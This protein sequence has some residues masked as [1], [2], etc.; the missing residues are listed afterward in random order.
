MLD[1]PL[2]ATLSS[3]CYIAWKTLPA[4][5]LDAQLTYLQNNYKSEK[6]RK[7]AYALV[8]DEFIS[9]VDFEGGN[10]A[11]AETELAEVLK[12][13]GF[14]NVYME[15]FD[16]R[17]ASVSGSAFPAN[18]TLTDPQGN[19]VDFATFRGSYVYVDLWASWCGPCCAE[20]PHLQKLEKELANSNVKFVSISLD[21]D[22]GAWKKKMEALNMHGN[23]LHNADNS[24]ADALG[25]RGI[26]FFVIYDKNGRLYKSNA[27]RP[28]DPSLKALLEGLK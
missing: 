17:K 16:K 8:I 19:K 27:P 2:A 7:N 4:G 18:V 6:I 22:E 9:K 11:E 5:S 1:T 28:S 12:K 23:Q 14:D 13:Y 3:T 15:K 25:V 10:F 20:V 24:L 21:K 26:P